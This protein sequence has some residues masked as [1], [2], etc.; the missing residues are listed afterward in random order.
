MSLLVPWLVFPIV[1][2]LIS[3]GCGLLIERFMG[4]GLSGA[5]I[6]P[7][8]LAVVIVAAEFTTMT[9][10]TARLTTPL[11]VALAAVGFALSFP[12]LRWRPDPFAILAAIGAFA[13][14]AA[15]VVLSGAATFTGYIKLDDTATWLAL[16]D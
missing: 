13:A 15:P 5:L 2:S 14:L 10:A 1:L 11:V 12:W 6:L 3:L 8:G 7:T 4:G 16:T 9:S